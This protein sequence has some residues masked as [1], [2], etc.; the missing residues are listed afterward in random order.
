ME[1]LA[2]SA[3]ADEDEQLLGRLIM[4]ESDRL[5]RLL[6]EFLDFSRVRA[7]NFSAVD[8]HEVALET[9]RLV[10]GHPDCGGSGPRGPRAS[11]R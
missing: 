8:L 6:G 3:S 4:R 11:A 1:Q 9:A 7:S 10:R 2:A 5:S